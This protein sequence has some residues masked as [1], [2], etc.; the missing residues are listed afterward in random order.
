MRRSLPS[1]V[2]RRHHTHRSKST[3][4]H[5]H[6]SDTLTTADNNREICFRL[7]NKSDKTAQ[8]LF[9]QPTLLHGV[10]KRMH[11]VIAV[12]F[13]NLE[14]LLLDAFIQT[15]RT[16]VNI[17]SHKLHNKYERPRNTPMEMYAGHVTCCPRRVTL[18]KYASHAPISIRNNT[19]R[20]GR[21]TRTQKLTRWPA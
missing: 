15:L 17:S 4:S 10:E 1:A 8:T 13:R 3:E 12:V 2:K 5:W 6:R 14:R 21:L 16:D 11:Q 20:Y 7:Q 18:I 19:I 9:P